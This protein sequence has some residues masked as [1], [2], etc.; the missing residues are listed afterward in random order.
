MKR[1]PYWWDVAGPPEPFNSEQVAPS[2][3]VAVVGA[4]LTGLSA[5]RTLAKSGKS[6]VCLDAGPPGIGASSRNGGMIGGGHRI[7]WD[8]L[9]ARHGD[10]VATELMR[11]MHLE[12]MAFAKGLMADEGIDCDFAQTG[13]LQ[14]L[15]SAAEYDS[16]AR[17]LEKVMK[18]I[19]LAAEMVPKSRVREDVSS[20][21][22]GGGV[23]YHE[24][25][26]LNPAKWVKGIR[27]AAV[28]AGAD[29]H[30]G[31]EVRS[32]ERSGSGWR[33]ETSGGRVDAGDV[34]LAT[35]G[36]TPAGIG[37]IA[38]R[39]FPIPS[40]IMATEELGANRVRDMFP[41]LRMIVETRLRHCYY[42][43]SPDG[44][45]VVFGGRA[46]MF[47]APERFTDSQLRG[48]MTGVL[49]DLRDASITHSWRGNTGFTFDLSPN[50]GQI[51]GVWHAIG[52]C[53]NGNAMAPWL[54]HK[55]A[56]SILGSPDG[57]TAFAETRLSGRWW[58]G[59]SPWFL[60]FADAYYRAK[61][62]WTD[63]RKPG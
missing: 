35:N 48:L 3:D 59:G 55:A 20:D 34:L 47:N 9:V 41:N 29:V 62:L 38:R 21:A 7:P 26:G 42:R 37:G 6:V 18:A 49:P 5:A 8:A 4:G 16:V 2:A 52:Y 27:D 43:P 30:G 31:T 58:Y 46:A 53:G 36:Y 23:L 13:R 63:L 39:V 28:R 50:V 57:R 40:F 60:P 45:R 1:T 24:H 56:L 14:A 33:L 17:N 54:G 61:D 15:W 12:S 19:P 25:G 32:V 11:E 10:S 51:D 22:Y 44:K